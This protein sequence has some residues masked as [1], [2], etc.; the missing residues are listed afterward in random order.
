MDTW[1]F[2]SLALRTCI[3]SVV[4]GCCCIVGVAAQFTSSSK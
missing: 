2:S 4:V 1:L 3:G